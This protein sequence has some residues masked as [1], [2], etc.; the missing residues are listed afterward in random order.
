ML[1]ASEVQS[2]LRGPGGDITEALA[3]LALERSASRRE[4]VTASQRRGEGRVIDG[5]YESAGGCNARKS[6][7]RVYAQPRNPLYLSPSRDATSPTARS[8]VA[9]RSSS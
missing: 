6:A 8:A 7:T 3:G 2:T 5:Y 9:N 4:Q 1:G